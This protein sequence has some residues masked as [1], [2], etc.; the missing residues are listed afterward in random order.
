[1]TIGIQKASLE[2]TISYDINTSS[3]ANASNS[4]GGVEVSLIYAWSIV[5]ET[6]EVKQKVCPKYL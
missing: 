3:L 4:R 5:K 1:M 2:A 6:K